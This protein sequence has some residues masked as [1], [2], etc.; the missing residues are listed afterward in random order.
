MLNLNSFIVDPPFDQHDNQARQH[1]VLPQVPRLLAGFAGDDGLG[2]DGDFLHRS[3]VAFVVVGGGDEVDGE[4]AGLA[5][6][7]GGV[8]AE[9]AGVRIGEV[10]SAAAVEAPAAAVR[11][12]D[13]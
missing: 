11:A 3:Q 4:T 8:D 10:G 2:A 1:D 13:L 7:L 9:Q 12:D 5:V 6:P